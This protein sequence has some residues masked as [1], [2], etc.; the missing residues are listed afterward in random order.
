MSVEVTVLMPVYNAEKYLTEAIDSVLNQ[1]F[2]DF[3]LL[4]INDGSTDKSVDIISQYSDKRIRL[5]HQANGGVSAALNTGLTHA[6]GKYIIR[7]D[8]DDI[9]HSN[10]IALQYKFMEENP[11]YILAGS[12]ADYITK[13]GEYIFTFTNKGHS[14]I[15]IRKFSTDSCPFIHSSVIYKKDVVLS[16]GG[17]EIKAHT[18]EDYFLWMKLLNK[19]KVYN[20]NTPLIKVRFNPES[21]TVDNKDYTK[22]FKLL[23]KKALATGVITDEEEVLILK[24]IKKLDANKKE[25]SYHRML[26]KKYLWNNYK[27]KEAR[28]HLISAIKLKP[29]QINGYGL[30]ILSFLPKKIIQKIY[31]SIK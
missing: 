14:D 25:I 21:V 16:L 27:P 8:A 12:D 9:C 17:Y 26:A 7:F 18:F 30:F 6:F 10:R 11:E 1:T 4:I 13:E 24:S 20:F 23:H 19:G 5:I 22:T 3:E 15:E 28:K 2:T 29:W 31:Q